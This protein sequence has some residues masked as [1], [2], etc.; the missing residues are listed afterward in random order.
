MSTKLQEL[1][2]EL[3]ELK[4]RR[5]AQE[6]ELSLIDDPVARVNF[7][8][9]HGKKGLPTT[10]QQICLWPKTAPWSSD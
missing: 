4:D 8:L 6:M 3:E 5:M 7:E 2:K 9:F 10:T 1:S